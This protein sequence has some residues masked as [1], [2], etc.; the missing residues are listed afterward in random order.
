MSDQ[1]SIEQNEI[2]NSVENH[3]VVTKNNQIVVD[4]NLTSE[5]SITQENE[6]FE[7]SNRILSSNTDFQKLE[8]P[9]NWSK[10]NNKLP[11]TTLVE[12]RPVQKKDISYP[13]NSEGRKFSNIYYKREWWINRSRLASLFCLK[14]LNFLPHKICR[15]GYSSDKL[16]TK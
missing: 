15:Y 5:L 11:I 14:L 10:I 13:R 2:N 8:D 4:Q 3:N 16:P 1:S 6:R 7:Q 9:S 12:H